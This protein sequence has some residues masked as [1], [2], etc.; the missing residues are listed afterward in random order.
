VTAEA[1][2]RIQRT[3]SLLVPEIILLGTACF[4][5]LAGPFA[6][7]EA[8]EGAR[9]LRHRWGLMS[10]LSLLLAGAVWLSGAA[11]TIQLGALFHTD[12][13]VWY[14][15]GLSLPAGILLA[16]VMWNQID[17]AHAAEAHACL[18][19][20]VA[21]TNLVAAASDLV[22]IFFYLVIVWFR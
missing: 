13:L 7:S 5:L 12:Q 1:I 3:A 20:I 15:R 18:L 17:D 10:L 8:G 4:L 14:T 11:D 21:G 9:G 22:C 16:L 2:E 19:A 6:V